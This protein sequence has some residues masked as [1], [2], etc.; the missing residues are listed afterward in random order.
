MPRFSALVENMTLGEL[1]TGWSEWGPS[2]LSWGSSMGQ[3]VTDSR[4]SMA[5]SY[6]YHVRST[7]PDGSLPFV[8][9]NHG[10]CSSQ[11]LDAGCARAS[12]PATS[13]PIHLHPSLWWCPGAVVN[14]SARQP[15]NPWTLMSRQDIL[16][17]YPLL[18]TGAFGTLFCQARP[19]RG[20]ARAWRAHT[21]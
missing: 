8:E 15:L 16:T 10:S 21:S 4:F 2:S 11:D 6:S 19:P 13:G 12:V 20:Q 7:S 5:D 3:Q 14:P 17:P 9:E 1:I 18:H